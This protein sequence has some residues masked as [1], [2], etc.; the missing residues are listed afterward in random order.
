MS[1]DALLEISD[2]PNHAPAFSKIEDDDF[3]PAVEKAIEIARDNIDAIKN[4]S[5]DPTYE[6]TIIALETASEALGQVTGIFYNQLSAMGGDTLHG[7]A[8]K[9]G[10]VTSNFSSDIILDPDLFARIKAV[11]DQKASLDLTA[12]EETLL[13]DTYKDFIRGGAAL[14][15]DKKARLRGISEALSTLGP[16]FM[17]NANKSA[18][19]FE[20]VVENEADLAGLPDSAVDAAKIAAEEKGYDGKWCFTL[21]YPSY[22]PFVQYADNRALRETIWRAFADRAWGDAFD[23]SENIKTIVSLKHERAQLLG[24]DTHAHFVLERRMAEKPENVMEFLDKMKAAYKPAAQRAGCSQ[25][26]CQGT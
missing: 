25:G 24:Y 8:E 16:S 7:L 2:L 14:P 5:E 13:D 9:I 3:L 1:V 17:N 23:N 19:A 12:E 11:Y 18:E 22:V 21:D 26:I 4:A 20:M 15:D 10:P 6:N